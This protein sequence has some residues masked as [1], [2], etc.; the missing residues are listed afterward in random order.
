MKRSESAR[1]GFT[2][3]ELMA[4]LGVVLLLVSLLLPALAKTSHLGRGVGCLGNLRQWAL[5][6]LG[7]AAEN[8]DFLPYDG[9]GNGTSIGSAWYADLPPHLGERPYHEQPA[10]RTNSALSLSRS[11]WL[12][13]ANRRRSDG[14]M[15]FHYSLNRLVNGSGAEAH[16]IRLGV[17]A[18]PARTVWLFDNGKKA[19]VAVAG[20]VHT[21]LHQSGANILFV[22]GHAARIP[23]AAYWDITKNRAKMDHPDLRWSG[24]GEE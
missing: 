22:D 9:A 4:V 3:V 10:W 7:F 21:N 5:G 2:L 17:V 23:R 20:N 14:R 11:V 18:E 12:C 15:L 13:P 6:T 1:G 8:S 24:K 19:A 16:R